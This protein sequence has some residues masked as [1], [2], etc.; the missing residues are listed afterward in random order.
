MTVTT[1]RYKLE[2]KTKM[3]LRVRGLISLAWVRET[4]VLIKMNKVQRHF[5]EMCDL[6]YHFQYI[7][8]ITGNTKGGS[9]TVPLTPV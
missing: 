4:F 9:I 7:L 1:I 3:Y 5:V 2:I 8:K 6:N